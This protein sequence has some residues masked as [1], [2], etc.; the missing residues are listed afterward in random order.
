[1]K[2]FGKEGSSSDILCRGPKYDPS[3]VIQS[4]LPSTWPSTTICNILVLIRLVGKECVRAVEARAAPGFRGSIL[5][6]MPRAQRICWPLVLLIP[7]Y[8][9]TRAGR[10]EMGSLGMRLQSV[11][12]P[13]TMWVFDVRGG[14]QSLPWQ[15]E[16]REGCRKGF[17]C[18]GEGVPEP[19]DGP[20]VIFFLWRVHQRLNSR[21]ANGGW[22]AQS[23][24]ILTSERHQSDLGPSMW[25]WKPPE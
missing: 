10:I 12:R 5:A 16:G 14:G 9:V 13:R 3:S 25:G 20:T 11:F 17:R 15:V 24:N 6:W 23:T 1:M 4:F 21:V 22:A 19:T 18:H 8:R 7:E 2:Q